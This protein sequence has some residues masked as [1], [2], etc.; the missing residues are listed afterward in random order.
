M[1]LTARHLPITKSQAHTIKHNVFV[2]N[3]ATDP[4]LGLQTIGEVVDRWK[5]FM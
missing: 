1:G 5:V 3:Q 4:Q 2:T